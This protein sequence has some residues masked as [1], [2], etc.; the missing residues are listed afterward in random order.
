MKSSKA[1]IA[2]L[3][4]QDTPL[5][6]HGLKMRPT[7]EIVLR[8][9]RKIEGSPHPITS[10]ATTQEIANLTQFNPHVVRARL[11]DLRR[12]QL[13]ESSELPR[14]DNRHR[15]RH[16]HAHALSLL[17]WQRMRQR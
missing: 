12:L 13:I 2:N 15:T 16:A 3:D 4:R 11:C 5:F 10:G 6:V 17:G 1:L 14:P 8:A 7:A 9:I